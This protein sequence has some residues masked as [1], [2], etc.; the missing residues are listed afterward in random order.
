M[1]ERM[2]RKGKPAYIVGGNVNWHSH[3]VKQYGGSSKNNL[4]IEV[5]H[6]VAIP[7]LGI[8]G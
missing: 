6:N 7:L 8:H 3:Y 5:P 2:W 1:L 4:K